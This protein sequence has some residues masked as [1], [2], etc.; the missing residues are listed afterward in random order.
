MKYTLVYTKLN[1]QTCWL[2]IYGAPA[3]LEKKQP[4]LDQ[5]DDN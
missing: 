3:I 4:H 2:G 5:L 1:A